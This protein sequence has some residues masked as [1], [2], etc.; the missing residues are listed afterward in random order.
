[1]AWNIARKKHKPVALLSLEGGGWVE[2]GHWPGCVK[3]GAA[4]TAEHARNL[5]FQACLAEMPTARE[6]MPRFAA[7]KYPPLATQRVLLE[8][9][10]WDDTEPGLS[11]LGRAFAEW[12]AGRA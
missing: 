10:L 9:G 8:R 12:I 6:D 1:M 3:R 5:Y 4:W 11:P 2:S 7:G